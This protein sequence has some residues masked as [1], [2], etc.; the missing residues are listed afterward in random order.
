MNME[1]LNMVAESHVERDVEPR[2]SRRPLCRVAVAHRALPLTVWEG[3]GLRAGGLVCQGSS[4][5]AGSPHTERVRGRGAAL[6]GR[7]S[8]RSGASQYRDFL[9]TS[10]EDG[11]GAPT[12]VRGARM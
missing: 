9:A 5:K 6:E 2:A 11:E 8:W 7:S 12:E 10:A 1:A 3:R 4:P